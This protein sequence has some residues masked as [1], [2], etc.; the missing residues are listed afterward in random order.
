[1][2]GVYFSDPSLKMY[3][4]LFFYSILILIVSPQAILEALIFDLRFEKPSQIQAITI[5][6]IIDK[7]DI[8]VQAQRFSFYNSYVYLNIYYVV[9]L[10]KLSP[11]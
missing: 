4:N 2:I 6:R 5:P 8:I 10:V 1:M 3:D 11:L 9:E 7:R